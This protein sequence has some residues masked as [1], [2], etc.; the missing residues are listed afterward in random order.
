MHYNIYNICNK[1]KI[2]FKKPLKF[3]NIFIQKLKIDKINHNIKYSNKFDL[4]TNKNKFNYYE[5]YKNIQ[6]NNDKWKLIVNND[7]YEK[8]KQN[9]FEYS[10]LK[11]KYKNYY[12]LKS[13]LNFLERFFYIKKL[14]YELFVNFYKILLIINKD[15]KNKLN[16]NNIIYDYKNTSIID[17]PLYFV[18]I[19]IYI[20]YVWKGYVIKSYDIKKY[21]DA[22]KYILEHPCNNETDHHLLTYDDK[23]NALKRFP[24]RS[25]Y[26]YNNMDYKCNVI[27]INEV[28]FIELIY[29]S[30]NAT[31]ENNIYEYYLVK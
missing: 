29:K 14:Y 11:N 9:N 15:K 4:F 19:F 17:P 28:L 16:I 22:K 13:K 3:T 21:V 18:I 25:E 2:N 10:I 23:M 30:S 20:N 6:I 12:N 1:M 24:I 8:I 7:I 5:T 27:I 26:Y 31:N